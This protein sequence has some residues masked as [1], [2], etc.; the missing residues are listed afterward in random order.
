M[1]PQ[2]MPFDI[3]IILS[4]R[5]LRSR[6]PRKRSLFST[7]RQDINSLFTRD[8]PLP[9]Q[10]WHQRN[11][12]ANKCDSSSFLLYIYLP[13]ACCPLKTR[14]VFLSHDIFL[15][16]LV[17]CCSCHRGWN[18]KPPLWILLA[19]VSLRWCVQPTLTISYFSPVHLSFC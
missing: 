10:R 16:C 6:N 17:L 5:Q 4:W 2:N 11:V 14:R 13:K 15:Q 7:W 9:A 12:C 18:F 8:R 19:S 3:K 1:T